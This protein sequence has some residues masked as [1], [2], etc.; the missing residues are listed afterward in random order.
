MEIALTKDQT[1]FLFLLSK[2]DEPEICRYI[3]GLKNKKEEIEAYNYHY[4]NWKKIA[5]SYFQ[6]LE[7][8]YPTYS[9]VLNGDQYIAEADNNLIFFYQTSISYQIRDLV[10]GLINEYREDNVSEEEKK[11]WRKEDDIIYGKL[12]RRIKEKMILSLC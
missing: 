1:I 6:C 7:N 3:I 9:Y 12:A 11:R 10:M 5:L 8:R 4:E 2:I